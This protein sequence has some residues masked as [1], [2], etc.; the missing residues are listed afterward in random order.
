MASQG[1]G[2]DLSASTYSPDGRIFQIEYAVKAVENAGTAIAVRT[3][4][5]VVFGVENLV[6]SKLMVSGS[7][8]RIF[9]VDRHAALTSA[10]LIADGKHLASRAR[11]EAN[12]FFDTYKQK[13]PIKTIAER[14]ALYVQAFT[15]YSS[16]R[17]FGASAIVGG[18][19]AE[20]GPQL[21]VI[22]PSG[23]V[24]GYHGCAVG[25][26]KQFAKTEIEKLALDE[27]S[28]EQ[29]VDEVARIIYKAH[30][31]AKDKEFELE[32]SWVGADGRHV[33]VPAELRD[34]AVRKALQSLDE[35]ME[36]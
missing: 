18:V 6:H 25:K 11:D 4:D 20:R 29:A 33:P 13:A 9:G 26:G 32:L 34:E 14:L 17:P 1:T 28:M 7:H 36:D 2:Y 19:D 12:N 30:D 23:M 35:D 15:L 21:Y 22:E 16:V 5:G 24:L 3:K 8:K 31:D 27:L 10:G